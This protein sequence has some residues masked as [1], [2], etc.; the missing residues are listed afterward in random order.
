MNATASIRAIFVAIICC[1]EIV[2]A[3]P[4]SPAPIK[5]PLRDYYLRNFSN[6]DLV[7]GALGQSPEPTLTWQ[8]KILLFKAHFT[9]SER[10][11]VF[12]TDQEEYLGAHGKYA[13]SVYFPVGENGYYLASGNNKIP[14]F[15][16]AGLSGPDY[17]GYIDEIKGY[18][19]VSGGRWAVEAIHIVEG[20][21]A[22]T[23]IDS[24]AA[25]NDAEVHPKYFSDQWK[26]RE[27]TTYTLAQLAAK[28]GKG[29]K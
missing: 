6:P 13:W 4:K 29:S 5:D 12:I 26:N 23:V 17:V 18:G 24:E 22:S 9:E 3:D 28:Y 11:S 10:K 16:S 15:V 2:S 7:R 27:I 8:T 14:D 1:T 21:L 25:H 19:V 20:F